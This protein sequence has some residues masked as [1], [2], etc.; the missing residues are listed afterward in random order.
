[1]K[2]KM[3][4]NKLMGVKQTQDFLTQGIPYPELRYRRTGRTLSRAL[5]TI[6]LA[7]H[8][9]GRSAPIRDHYHNSRA[10]RLLAQTIREIISKMELECFV[11]DEQNLTL[12]YD[13]YEIAEFELLEKPESK[14]EI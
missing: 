11:L 1:M 12:T 7:M 5:Y 3:L 13:I 10:D 8:Y 14:G 6:A 2:Q 4:Y 9:P